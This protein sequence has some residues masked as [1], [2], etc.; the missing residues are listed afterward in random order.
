MNL[1]EILALHYRLLRSFRHDLRSR[2]GVNLLNIYLVPSGNFIKICIQNQL[3]NPNY[4][5]ISF[6]DH[7]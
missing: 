4:D 7:S 1:D 3:E 6:H 5:F 2:M